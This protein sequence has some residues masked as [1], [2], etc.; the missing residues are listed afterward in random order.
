[1]L[2]SLPD[3]PAATAATNTVALSHVAVSPLFQTRNFTYRTD[4]GVYRQDPYAGFLIDPDRALAEAIRGR[5][6]AQG[7]AFGHVIEPGGEIVTTVNLEARVTELYGDLCK[8]DDCAGVMAIHFTIYEVNPD[9]PGRVL[10]DQTLTRRAPMSKHTPAALMAAW[11]EWTLL[12]ILQQLQSDYA[13]AS[14]T[15]R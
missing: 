3:P 9:G 1:M 8:R 5:M 7:G 11:N 13:K 10:L 2:F 15:D 12:H 14:L 6:R 4:E